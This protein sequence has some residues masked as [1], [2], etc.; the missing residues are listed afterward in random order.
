MEEGHFLIMDQEV[1]LAAALL[2][3]ALARPTADQTMVSLW[4]VVALALGRQD[5]A[6]LLLEEAVRRRCGLAPLLLAWPQIASYDHTPALRAF[7]QAMARSFGGFDA[8][9]A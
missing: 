1:D 8:A 9:V 6:A 4:G 5:R 7:R 3:Q 2:D